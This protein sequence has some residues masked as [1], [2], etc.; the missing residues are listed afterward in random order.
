[1]QSVISY[2]DRGNYGNSKYR[3][4]C[5]GNVIKD[6]ISQFYPNSKHEFVILPMVVSNHNKI[7]PP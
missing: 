7:L 1:M 3:G 6:L 2:K 4:N 5:S